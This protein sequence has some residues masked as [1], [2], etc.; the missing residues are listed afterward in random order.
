MRMSLLVATLALVISAPALGQTPM[1]PAQ[2]IA[3]AAKASNGEVEGVF[4]FDVGSGG[5]SGFVSYLNSAA[6][7]RDPANLS[8]ELHAAAVNALRTRFG[9]EPQDVLK[10]KRVRV[11]GVARRVPIPADNPRYHQTRIAVDS[12]VQVEILN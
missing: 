4:E 2:A 8:V 3:A 5:A 9:G 12:A 11:K 6:D 1:T 7:Y 10:G